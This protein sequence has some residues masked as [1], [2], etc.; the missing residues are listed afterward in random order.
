MSGSQLKNSYYAA[1]RMLRDE[2]TGRIF[3][4]DIREDL[5]EAFEASGEDIPDDPV[6]GLPRNKRE[7]KS[8]LANAHTQEE[9]E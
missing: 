8:Y 5:I 6:S 7:L 4:F 3:S 2:Y 9:G 1:L